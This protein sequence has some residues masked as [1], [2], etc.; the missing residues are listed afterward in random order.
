MGIS[1]ASTTLKANSLEPGAAS[2]DRAILGGSP[3]RAA[4]LAAPPESERPGWRASL[5]HGASAWPAL[6]DLLGARAGVEFE[7]PRAGR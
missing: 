2:A 3:G 4:R 6:R 7:P 1:P 5:E